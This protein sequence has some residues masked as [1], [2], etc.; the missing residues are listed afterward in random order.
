[1]GRCSQTI[2][3]LK[4]PIVLQVLSQV[5]RRHAAFAQV[6]LDPVAVGQGG[7]EPGGD[8]GHGA[9]MDCLWGFGEVGGGFLGPRSSQ[10]NGTIL[11]VSEA[12]ATSGALACQGCM[13][14]GRIPWKTPSSR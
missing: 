14:E 9:K 13:S 12:R 5:H 6:A 4:S 2:S 8:L 3:D 10:A 1:M 7:R 11:I